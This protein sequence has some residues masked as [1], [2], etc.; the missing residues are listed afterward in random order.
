MYKNLS[1]N[2]LLERLQSHSLQRLVPP[3]VLPRC[4]HSITRFVAKFLIVACLVS[5][6]GFAVPLCNGAIQ[7]KR[8]VDAAANVAASE[9]VRSD[10]LNAFAREV[11]AGNIAVIVL[12]HRAAIVD[13]VT[14]F[15]T[16]FS[17]VS[18]TNEQRLTSLR[19]VT[20]LHRQVYINILSD[21]D[22]LG[23]P[24]FSRNR[25]ILLRTMNQIGRL[26]RAVPP[27]IRTL[28][29]QQNLWAPEGYPNAN[30]TFPNSYVAFAANAVRVHLAVANDQNLWNRPAVAGAVAWR[31]NTIAERTFSALLPNFA[32]YA[33]FAAVPSS[34]NFISWPLRPRGLQITVTNGTDYAQWLAT[35]PYVG[36]GGVTV[37]QTAMQSQIALRT[38]ARTYSLIVGLPGAHAEIR[39]LNDLLQVPTQVDLMANPIV[40]G[41]M[42]MSNAAVHTISLE[43]GCDVAGFLCCRGCSDVLGRGFALP[44]AGGGT[45]DNPL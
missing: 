36:M 26:Y 30:V 12:S 8:A 7:A 23:A 18:L 40:S 32:D 42:K 29:V 28:A 5:N 37:L 10:A 44:T 45:L 43:P 2:L 24:R 19:N 22:P 33:S 11:A 38:N 4:M 14:A 15:S 16:F 39:A 1:S 27:D 35:N 31:S 6:S 21:T 25:E 17:G 34:A 3:S 20:R 13:F 9:Q 41:E